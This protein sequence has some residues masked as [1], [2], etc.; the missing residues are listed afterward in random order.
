MFNRGQLSPNDI[1]IE[2]TV[3]AQFD[4]SN[5]L[6]F[7][8]GATSGTT[9]HFKG[10]FRLSEV[11]TYK[12]LFDAP[13]SG[14]NAE[15]FRIYIYE[16]KFYVADG[17][18]N[19]RRTKNLFRDIQGWVDWEVIGDTSNADPA[20]RLRVL[21]NGVEP[22]YDN[23]DPVSQNYV[24]GINR[25][26]TCHI[27]CNSQTP[28][29]NGW[30]GYMDFIE[31]V[32][33]WKLD[34]EEIGN[35]GKDVSGNDNNWTPHFVY[36]DDV[37]DANLGF[38]TLNALVPSKD[39]A[40]S[41]G[42]LKVKAAAG[43]SSWAEQVATLAFP[44]SGKWWVA[45]KC[46][47]VPNWNMAVVPATS[48]N[49]SGIGGSNQF[50]DS[51]CIEVH[52]RDTRKNNAL[53]GNDVLPTYVAN[54]EW[55]L[56][57][58]R[59]ADKID[60]YID[61][62]FNQTCF[63]GEMG[64]GNWIFAVGAYD[65]ATV[66]VDFG[67][68]G[69]VAQADAKFLA[70][71]NLPDFNYDPA[72]YTEILETPAGNG[73]ARTI[74]GNMNAQ[75]DDQLVIGKARTIDYAWYWQDTKRGATKNLSSNNNSGDTPAQSQSIT[76]I[77]DTGFTL[78]TDATWNA[79]GE[80]FLHLRLRE[81]PHFRMLTYS[82]NGGSRAFDLTASGEGWGW[83]SDGFGDDVFVIVK[84]TDGPGA[85]YVWNSNIGLD[86]AAG[87]Y[88]TLDSD[89]GA[90]ADGATT[91]HMGVSPSSSGFTVGASIN[92]VGEQYVAY[93]FRTVPGLCDA[94]EYTGNNSDD[95]PFIPLTGR[96]FFMAKAYNSGNGH[97]WMVMDTGR[98]PDNP[99]FEN[100]RMSESSAENTTYPQLDFVTGGVKL[101]TT[102]NAN[103]ANAGY[104]GLALHTEA[105]IS[106]D[107]QSIM[108]GR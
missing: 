61:G 38:A 46:D 103:Y 10:R 93:V 106:K 71:A 49:E 39:G 58:D 6:S 23:N 97:P 64:D 108:E 25:A 36:S 56:L 54:Q 35:A 88:L 11:T 43:A 101:R 70:Q 104:I 74:A 107:K 55:A 27:G 57:V 9:F 29:T 99:A 42:N 48:I 1:A 85:W 7:A 76:A 15:F 72:D 41:E 53:V 44:K 83:D 32:G 22:E 81:G 89:N 68:G 2:P 90:F 4:G 92:T 28:G 86:I 13:N 51:L 75:G 16:Q 50:T 84:R 73:S 94:F 24:F 100:L 67:Q 102:A 80:D 33:Q 79:A 78:G 77:S 26:G 98:S 45:V 12:Y 63:T 69:T 19:W 52:G 65:G 40:L 87:Q 17:A 20:L 82:G 96:G 60:L 5:Y 21:I 91:V 14:V 34:F 18:N 31:H 66:A 62:A 8:K 59:D 3:A 95:G 47:I 30:E 105:L 37:L